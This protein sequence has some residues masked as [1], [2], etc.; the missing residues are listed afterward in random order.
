MD[1]NPNLKRDNENEDSGSPKRIRLQEETTEESGSIEKFHD[2]DLVTIKEESLS[3]EENNESEGN[4]VGLREADVG[5]V[6]YV[7][8][9]EGFQG[10][11]KQRYQDFVVNEQNKS[12]EVVRLSHLEP[13]ENDI[14]TPVSSTSPAIAPKDIGRLNDLLQSNNRSNSVNIMVSTDDKETRTRMHQEVR[15]FSS[16][17]ES[18][19]TVVDGQKMITVTFATQEGRKRKKSGW[20]KNRPEY[21]KF[22]LYKENKDINDAI[23][24]ICKYLQMNTNLFAF[25]GSKDKRAITVQEVTAKKVTATRLSQL[26]KVLRGIKLGNF[27]YVK[28]P[29]SLGNLSGNHFVIILR[30]VTGEDDAVNKAMCS[31]RDIGFINYFGMQRFGNSLIATH[32]IGRAILLRNWQEVIELI[33]KPRDEADERDKWRVHW[34]ETK[35]AN[36]TL[37]LL[38][39][40]KRHSA[41]KELLLGILKYPGKPISALSYIP[42]TTRMMYVHSYQSKI[43]NAMATKRIQEYGL[44]PMIG[45]LAI[46]ANDTDGDSG[47][48]VTVLSE[49]NFS[50]FSFE[51]V[52]LPQPGYN[53]QYPTHSI[54]QL[55]KSMMEEDGVSLQSLRHEVKEYSLPGAYRKVIVKPLKVKWS[56]IKYNDSL[57]P[58][59]Q[60]DLDIIEGK[61]SPQSIPDGKLKALKMEFTLPPSSYATMAVR[62]VTKMDTSASFQS[63]ITK[64]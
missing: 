10:V 14:E 42:R 50:K 31:L 20:P 53:I 21:C 12:G 4:L 49:S 3:A 51:D 64:Y 48:N 56:I 8:E 9:E 59:S 29:L 19:T 35:D 40:N 17:L 25:A 13:P 30:N 52:V 5:I 36:S 18:S 44:K 43:W 28:T 58:L 6:E 32:E 38:P 61:A 46:K 22:A 41:E 47:K 33:L 62:E 54:G 45:D 57:L 23:N 7:N 63:S 15:K 60:S 24:I 39:S 1:E 34:M 2:S 55:Y 11:L 27:S 16:K 37:E 26:N